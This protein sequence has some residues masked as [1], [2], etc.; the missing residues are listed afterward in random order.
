MLEI[1][2]EGIVKRLTCD[3]GKKHNSIEGRR[4]CRAK[5]IRDGDLERQSRER[6]EGP[7]QYL[8]GGPRAL[9]D[10]GHEKRDHHK[11]GHGACEACEC[12]SFRD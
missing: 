11:T 12:P 7:V 2:V 9:C 8:C 6:V 1:R 3:C 10:C 5:A 4:K